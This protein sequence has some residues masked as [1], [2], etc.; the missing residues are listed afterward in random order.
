MRYVGDSLDMSMFYQLKVSFNMG[1]FS[2]SQHRRG[3]SRGGVLGVTTPP[4]LL[5]DP[6]T[7]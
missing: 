5:G 2:D 3:G 6:Q 7:S 1:T 4:P